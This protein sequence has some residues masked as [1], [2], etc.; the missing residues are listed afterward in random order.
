MLVPRGAAWDAYA[1]R[2]EALTD[3]GEQVALT[4]TVFVAAP[5]EVTPLPGQAA[6]GCFAREPV[7]DAGE[8]KIHFYNR[9]TDDAGGPL[10]T[11]KRPTREAE[12]TALARHVR[13][14]DPA[15]LR[16]K[17]RSWLYNLEAYRR[18]FPPDYVAS[19]TAAA[20]PIHLSGTSSWG[21]LIDAREAIRPD[22]RDAFLAN[23]ARLDPAAPW[24]IFPHPVLEVSAPME[25]FYRHF[26]V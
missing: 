1:E 15:A 11:P 3:I 20:E 12:L 16:L 18:L 7:N 24:R 2:L 6:F 8:V 25:S 9:D 21:Q 13:E 4:Q 22:V 5:P 26:G 23:F 10:A 17:G 19:R 14:V